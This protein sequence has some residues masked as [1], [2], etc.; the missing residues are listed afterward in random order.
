MVGVGSTFRIPGLRKFIGQQLQVDVQRLVQGD[1]MW[2]PI[3][4][5]ITGEDVATLRSLGEQ[6]ASVLEATPGSFMIRNN[7]REDAYALEVDLRPEV[8]N[9]LGMSATVVSNMLA[10]TFRGMP[11][12]TFWEGDDAVDIVLQLDESHRD[13]F[14]DLERKAE[15]RTVYDV[16]HAPAWGWKVSAYLFTKSISGGAWLA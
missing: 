2:A 7:F 6:A 11:V 10:G 16:D 4:V 12:S 1:P 5:R 9:R 13:A 14:E 3:E 15:A 8:A